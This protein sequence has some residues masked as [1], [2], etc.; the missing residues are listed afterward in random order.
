[1]DIKNSGVVVKIHLPKKSIDAIRGYTN[2]MKKA[3]Y[4][5]EVVYGIMLEIGYEQRKT[6]AERIMQRSK[7]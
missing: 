2:E 6:I 7:A 1:M 5:K 3:G 4:S